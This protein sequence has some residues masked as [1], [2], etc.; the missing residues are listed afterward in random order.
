[1]ETKT[2]DKDEMVL[3]II[4]NKLN[5]EMARIVIDRSH[6]LEKRKCLG[7]KPQAIIVT[8]TQ[9]IDRHLLLR[10]ISATESLTLKWMKHANKGRE[11]PGFAN[12]GTLDG[13][14]MFKGNDGNQKCIILKWFLQNSQR[15]GKN[16]T[17][18]FAFL[19]C[20]GFN[21]WGMS[22]LIFK[23]YFFYLWS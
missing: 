20:L 22:Q 6:R 12:A 15:T 9:Y 23:L 16:F 8:F 10:N 4:N 1:M 11:E 5:I 21:C 3:P 17:V 2:K 19:L 7:Q 18:V 13:M 14:I